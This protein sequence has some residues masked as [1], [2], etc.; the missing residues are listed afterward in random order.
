MPCSTG[1]RLGHA[2]I[3]SGEIAQIN[4]ELRLSHPVAV[5]LE[6]CGEANAFYGPG[7]RHIVFC[8]EFTPYLE[9]VE[10]VLGR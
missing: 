5:S 6:S 9:R 4:E 10:D 3:L 1:R 7:E 2:Q 8:S